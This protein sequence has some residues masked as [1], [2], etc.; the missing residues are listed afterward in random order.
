M[1]QI[2]RLLYNV[3]NILTFFKNFTQNYTNY[4][5]GCK[6]VSNL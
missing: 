1:V 4:D 6:N 3:P 2:Y 5:D